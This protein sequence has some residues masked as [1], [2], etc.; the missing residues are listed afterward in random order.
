MRSWMIGVVGMGLMGCANWP[1][2]GRGGMAEH[3]PLLLSWLDSEGQQPLGPEHGLLFEATLAKHHLD[4]LVVEGAELCFPAS[5][6]Q[7]RLREQRILREL[8]GGLPHDAASDIKAQQG[9]LATLEKRLDYVKGAGACQ[10][11]LLSNQATGQWRSSIEPL[12]NSNN[13]FATDTARLTPA[14]QDQ[15]RRVIPLL[16][17]TAFALQ[18]TGHTDRRGD[19][20]YNL[21]LSEARAQAVA[22]YLTRSGIAV[23]R[24]RIS[25]AGALQA[26]AGGES[27]EHDHS[28]RRV[29]IAL[30]DASQPGSQP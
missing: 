12:L 8:E 30:V 28:N 1:D 19:A 27:V 15:L 11:E 7:A 24:I 14:Y 4:M 9:F 21:Q 17:Q 6:T 22:D 16:Q 23:S 20:A 29:T 3:Q 13:Q 25:G 26:Y 18:I 2:A 10:P 5:V